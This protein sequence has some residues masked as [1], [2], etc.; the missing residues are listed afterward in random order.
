[1]NLVHGYHWDNSGPTVAV[2]NMGGDL[3]VLIPTERVLT[4]WARV[5]RECHGK[6]TIES[7]TV[8]GAYTVQGPGTAAAPAVP[9]TAVIPVLSTDQLLMRVACS[10]FPANL[11]AHLRLLNLSDIA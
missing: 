3:A 4:T 10:G 5:D 6:G 9:M 7:P 1:M 11:R 8:L 2:R